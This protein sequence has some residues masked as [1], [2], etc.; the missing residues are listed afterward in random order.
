[1]CVCVCVGNGELWATGKGEMGR[2]GCGTNA[3]SLDFK[4]RVN[5]ASLCIACSVGMWVCLSNVNSEGVWVSLISA[6]NA[7]SLDYKV[8]V[9]VCTCV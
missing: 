4:V 6:N 7:D 3:D 9:C 5:D 8:R 1:M 2:L